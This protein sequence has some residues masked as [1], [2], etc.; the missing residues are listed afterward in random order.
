MNAVLN[1]IGSQGPVRNPLARETI[2]CRVEVTTAMFLAGAE[3]KNGEPQKLRQEGLRP[4]S[5]KG[6]LRAWWRLARPEPTSELAVND[7]RIWGALPTQQQ[8][9]PPRGIIVRTRFPLAAE[10][11][12]PRAERPIEDGPGSADFYLG[13]GAIRNRNKPSENPGKAWWASGSSFILDVQPTTAEQVEAVQTALR[14]WCLFGG[15]GN[16]S[17][18]TWGGIWIHDIVP[19]PATVDALRQ[20]I[21]LPEGRTPA[22]RPSLLGARAAVRDRGLLPEGQGR[23]R[24]DR[25]RTRHRAGRTEAAQ[26]EGGR[27]REPA[28]RL[29][30]GQRR[31]DPPPPDLRRTM[32]GM[33]RQ[34]GDT[35][36]PEKKQD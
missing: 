24:P 18:R 17:R 26:G 33:A 9:H 29:P 13:Y 6:V 23:S 11:G 34:V 25:P 3:P 16:R 5:V 2:T 19:R 22:D 32:P 30:P 4:A 27:C 7:Q 12:Q 8:R 14:L 21:R 15:L 20:A 28:H 1:L 31:R 36:K 35:Y 10:P